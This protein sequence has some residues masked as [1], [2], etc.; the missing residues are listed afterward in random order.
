[1]VQ[2]TPRQVPCKF[3]D[4]VRGEFVIARRPRG[5]EKPVPLTPA[6]LED[7]RSTAVSTRLGALDELA[8]WLSGTHIGRVLAATEA[9]QHV[10]STDDSFRVRTRAQELLDEHREAYER[11]LS[12]APE[13]ITVLP[14]RPAPPPGRPE[15]TSPTEPP[16]PGRTSEPPG[17]DL[18]ARWMTWALGE[19]DGDR[20]LAAAA[21]EAA[22]ASA[23]A[24]ADAGAAA[25]AG[26]QAI[27]TRRAPAAPTPATPPTPPPAPPTRPVT[28]PTAPTGPL[29]PAG[30]PSQATI[31]LVLGVLSPLTCWL[32]FILGPIAMWYGHNAQQRIKASTGRAGGLAQARAGFWLG[33]TGMGVALVELLIVFINR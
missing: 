29:A 31:A 30:T 1:V 21:V 3:A 24:G 19:A 26:R 22:L 8:V 12:E 18:R 15:V 25:E 9:L 5:T 6:L 2:E 27:A 14:T 10:A 20:D 7:L 4:D 16:Q 32:G 13:R 11:S 33:L 28:P 23:A 17:E